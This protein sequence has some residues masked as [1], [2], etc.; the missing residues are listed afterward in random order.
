M[1]QAGIAEIFAS[2]NI[3]TTVFCRE[4]LHASP[5]TL[6]RSKVTGWYPAALADLIPVLGFSDLFLSASFRVIRIAASHDG[7]SRTR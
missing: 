7:S 6:V 1:L 2:D 5:G 3:G 4:P